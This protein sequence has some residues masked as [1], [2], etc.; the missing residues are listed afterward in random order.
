MSSNERRQGGISPRQLQ[1][2]TQL[3]ILV[4]LVASLRQ[5]SVLSNRVG[6][7]VLS[8]CKFQLRSHSRDCPWGVLQIRRDARLGDFWFRS[9][10]HRLWGES[11]SLL[12]AL[13]PRRE[14]STD[15][16]GVGD[17]LKTVHYAFKIGWV[18]G[19]QLWQQ[20]PPATSA[21][22]CPRKPNSQFRQQWQK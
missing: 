12:L 21:C 11:S 16:S 10:S 3:R 2:C 4:C 1:Y 8:N 14:T 17:E 6:P 15:K 5:R 19:F 18:D 20:R 9:A 22:L 7:R 13:L